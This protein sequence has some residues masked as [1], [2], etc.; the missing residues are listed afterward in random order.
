MAFCMTPLYSWALNQTATEPSSNDLFETGS[1]V[2][3][4]VLDTLDSTFCEHLADI[5]GF[6]NHLKYNAEQHNDS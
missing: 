1:R 2:D 5:Q 4:S 3:H 6:H